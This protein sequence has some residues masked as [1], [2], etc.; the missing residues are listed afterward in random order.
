MAYHS[1]GALSLIALVVMVML[2]ACRPQLNSAPAGVITGETKV[3]HAVTLSFDGPELTESRETFLNYR[4]DLSLTSPSGQQKYYAGY[5]AADGEAAETSAD[6]GR[7]WQVTFNPNEAGEWHYK[8]IFKTGP[9]AAIEDNDNVISAGYFDGAEGH[10][11]IADVNLDPKAHDFRKKGVLADV[12][13]RYLQYQGTQDYFLK[14]GAGSPENILAFEGF[15]G[16]YDAGGINFPALGDNQLHEFEPHLRDAMPNDPTWQ[17]G[18]GAAILGVA[19]YYKSVGVNAQYLVAMNV[20][21]DGQD[22]FPWTAHNQPYIFDISKLAQWQRV[23]SHF[24]H[25]GVLID[26]LFTECE[27]ESIFEAWDGVE[28]GR[29]F[30][31]SRKLYY[32]EMI[33]RFGHLNGII[34]NL[35]E[36]NGVIGNTGRS[37][38]RDPT[39]PR[40]RGLFA[41]Y[42]AEL[43][44]Y[45]HAIVSH[46]WPDEEDAFYGDLLG[47]DNFSGIS[48]QAHD[49]YFGKIAEWT[50]RSE[51]AGRAWL[52][53]VDE[54]LGWEFGAR[55]DSEAPRHDKELSEVLW[56]S[57]MAGG[58]GV[59][60]YFGWQNN[61]PTSDLSNEDQRSRHNLWVKSA[62]V[63]NWWEDNLPFWD[64]KAV[65]PNEGEP[66]FA[67]PNANRASSDDEAYD[68]ILGYAEEELVLIENGTTKPIKLPPFDKE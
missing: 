1:K 22:V 63:R 54:P 29:D 15:D 11:E 55:P 24:N 10:F 9:K 20:E 16:T 30:A 26:F 56:P 14:T 41:D 40:Q 50:E 51:Q 39:T 31:D 37:P 25:Q 4:L 68:L 35:G 28:I 27:N 59:D 23:L 34:W 66:F 38:Y 61:A 67:R 8:A 19:N 46:N 36:E 32:R 60:W 5:F 47:H 3:W 62:Q 53:M 21:G 57:L 58:A 17:G 6:R 42:I 65:I 48:L 44:P 7:K 12:K 13:A 18:K 64:M 52:V 33:A 2:L 43:D 45:D 49:N